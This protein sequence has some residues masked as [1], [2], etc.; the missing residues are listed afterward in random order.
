M[1]VLEI[2]H[3]KKR[4]GNLQVIDGLDLSVTEHSVFGFLGQNGA[5]KTT[6]MKMI[7]GLLKPD[8][9]RITVCGQPVTYDSDRLPDGV[10]YLP[11]VPEFYPFMTPAEYLK[12]C[13]QIAGMQEDQIRR[14]SERLLSLTGLAGINRKIAGFSRGM[15]QRLGIAQALL[16]DPKLL[17]C[18]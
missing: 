5:G 11:D 9:G 13:G 10:G 1:H 3:L 15:R 16:N 6:T 2:S 14:Q 12:L 8:D 7:L 18:D 4:F 17:I